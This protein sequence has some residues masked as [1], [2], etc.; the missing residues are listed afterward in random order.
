MHVV[1]LVVGKA[2]TKEILRLG[3][4]KGAILGVEGGVASVVYRIVWLGSLVPLHWVFVSNDGV[5]SSPILEV[6]MFDNACER[7]FAVGVIDHRSA[8]I[9]G[10]REL[11]LLEAERAV[12]QLAVSVVVETVKFTRIEHLFGHSIELLAVVEV[13]G[14]EAHLN[15]LQKS[16][17]QRIIATYRDTLIGVVEVVVVALEA[18][19]QAANNPR[20]KL[21]ARSTP[22]LLGVALDKFFVDICPHQRQRLLLEISRLAVEVESLLL[23]LCLSLLGTLHTP[24]RIEGVEVEWQRIDFALL[25]GEW[26]VDKWFELHKRVDKVPYLLV[27]GVEDM[28][29]VLVDKDSALLLAVAVSTRMATT[30]NDQHP[31]ARL[32]GTI[33]SY[34]TI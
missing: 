29:S 22:L 30:I 11:L 5:V 7:G 18:E 26:R 17:D 10:L 32:S 20:R 9:V 24:Q 8:L 34:G 27:R 25:V 21:T 14:V 13:V 12:L 6:L 33:G 28:R 4:G 2:T 19:W 31:L 1:I 15:T 23:D 16:V 3:I